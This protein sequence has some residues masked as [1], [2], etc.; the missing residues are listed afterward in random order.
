MP[1]SERGGFA[2]YRQASHSAMASSC[3]RLGI[4]ARAPREPAQSYPG[5][6][7][8]VGRWARSASAAAAER[9]RALLGA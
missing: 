2:M 4:A 1:S 5:A 7:A 9:R 6:G 3:A 8:A